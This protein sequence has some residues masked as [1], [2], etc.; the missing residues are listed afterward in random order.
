MTTENNDEI[1]IETKHFGKIKIKENEMLKFPNGI[2]AFEGFTNYVILP[3]HKDSVFHWLQS[4]DDPKLSFLLLE[5]YLLLPEY[6]PD[7]FVYEIENLF[8]NRD[9]SNLS[10]W[11]IVTIPPNHPEKMTI[12]AQGPIVISNEK[13]LGGQFISNNESH[14]VRTPV[15]ELVEA[16]V[17]T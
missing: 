4:L 8:G 6:V 3:E 5:P 13:R 2:L 14:L 16:G 11:C 1:E 15:L 10:V 9:I 7:I 17:L 12:N